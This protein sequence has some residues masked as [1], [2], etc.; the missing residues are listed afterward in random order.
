M[1]SDE[2]KHRVIDYILCYSKGLIE[3]DRVLGEAYERGEVTTEE[4]EEFVDQCKATL[5]ANVSGLTTKALNV[6]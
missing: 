3:D 4:L 2:Q 5:H 1:L 6:K